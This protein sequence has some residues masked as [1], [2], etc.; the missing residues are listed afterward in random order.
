[1]ALPAAR[2]MAALWMLSAVY[3]IWAGNGVGV[4]LVIIWVS[5][6]LVLALLTVRITSPV[7][8]GDTD[9]APRGGRV[10]AQ[11][12]VVGVV[13]L[14]TGL[15]ALGVSALGEA[16]GWS[17]LVDW[18]RQAGQSLFS[19][20]W[21]GGPGNAMAN[22]VQY[23]VIPFGLLL[24]LGASPRDVGLGR[25]RD[26]W[27]VCALW[28]ALP[29]V[30]WA[31]L[32]AMGML[33][34]PVLGRR[35]L[36]NALQNGFFEEFLFRG[37]L[38]TRLNALMPANWALV[39]QALLFGLWHLGANMR[40]MDG[41]LLAGLALCVISQGVVGISYGIV[42]QRTRNLAAPSV[43]HVVM[44]AFGQTFGGA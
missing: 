14:L 12:A 31:V 2:L 41:S 23:F 18:L 25:G 27:R 22:P 39:L 30:T 19:V 7:P 15:D 10:W 44:N 4:I 36:S 40:M 6:G 35:L 17:P 21:V 1:M 13:I 37:A 28:L 34:L 26:V 38:Q 20:A 24:L 29:L 16:L 3:L 11:L 9:V 33:T 32:L 8:G 43:A 5:V 42:F